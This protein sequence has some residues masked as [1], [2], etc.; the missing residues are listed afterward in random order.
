MFGKRRLLWGCREGMEPVCCAWEVTSN[1]IDRIEWRRDD[2]VEERGVS[3]TAEW[4][5]DR[6]IAFKI[7]GI[8]KNLT[9]DLTDTSP[10]KR[11]ST[12]YDMKNRNHT[13]MSYPHIPVSMANIQ[14]TDNTAC[15]WECEANC[16]PNG[17]HEIR[18]SLTIWSSHCAP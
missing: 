11:C 7:H 3:N 14:S 18:C 8:I 1:F 16:L 15:W 6:I 12:S 5:H 2:K 10:K 17:L 13:T 4:L 9:K